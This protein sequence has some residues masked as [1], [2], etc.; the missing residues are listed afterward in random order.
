V[1]TE[2]ATPLVL[3]DRAAEQTV[4]AQ[5]LNRR[6]IWVTWVEESQRVEVR[7]WPIDVLLPQS[8]VGSR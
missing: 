2:G 3:Q 7:R 1:W 6:E 4:I 8:V 5:P